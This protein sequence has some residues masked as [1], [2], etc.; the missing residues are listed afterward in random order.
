MASHGGIARKIIESNDFGIIPGAYDVLTAYSV[1]QAGF[2]MVYFAIRDMSYG[3]AY[4]DIGILNLSD[5]CD[6]LEPVSQ[7]LS[8]PF[9]VELP[10]V[11]ESE[12]QVYR[13]IHRLES[14]GCAGVV[15]DDVKYRT[16]SWENFELAN[17][18]EFLSRIASV[19]S[20]LSNAD[21]LV[22]AKVEASRLLSI[23]EGIDRAT[24]AHH[25]DVDFIILSDCSSEFEAAE[26]S[27][28]APGKH[29]IYC[30]PENKCAEVGAS[31]IRNL[32]FKAAIIPGGLLLAAA[33]AVEDTLQSMNILKW[34]FV[35]S[36]VGSGAASPGINKRW[37]HAHYKTRKNN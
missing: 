32:L 21:M 7:Q 9:I 26:F 31:G 10:W 12:M 34:G 37:L 28:R 22:I 3:R 1:E 6:L 11:G 14:L 5:V 17:I 8:I 25:L 4:P 15:I 24:A 35:A 20:S 33:D 30:S 19:K 23:E 29:L 18:D 27:R 13:S 2:P 16:I 36:H